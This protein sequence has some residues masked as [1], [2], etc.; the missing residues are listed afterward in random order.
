MCRR[1]VST[2]CS[3]MGPDW[4]GR[5]GAPLSWRAAS[6]MCVVMQVHA[7][8]Q[9]SAHRIRVPGADLSERDRG[10]VRTSSDHSRSVE[11]TTRSSSRTGPSH[12]SV[13]RCNS[14]TPTCQLPLGRTTANWRKAASPLPCQL[15]GRRRK[16]RGNRNGA[17][18]NRKGALG[19]RCF[20][21]RR[22]WR[23]SSH[24]GS[25]AASTEAR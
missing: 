24:L 20:E 14:A 9:R 5:I 19:S 18:R 22:E 8:H 1:Q 23:S 13:Q 25:V 21:K 6:W 7:M 12:Q 17:Q 10:R 3:M 2:D 16:A 4:H 11:Y 15:S